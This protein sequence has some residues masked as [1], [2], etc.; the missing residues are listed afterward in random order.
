MA[1]GTTTY[2]RT[3]MHNLVSGQAYFRKRCG[4]CGYFNKSLFARLPWL[5]LWTRDAEE[6]ARAEAEA[7]ERRAFTR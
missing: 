6:A 7:R 1:R 2:T 3:R 4:S 5:E